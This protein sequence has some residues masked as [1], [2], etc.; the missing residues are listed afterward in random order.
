MESFATDGWIRRVHRLTPLTDQERSVKSR[1]RKEGISFKSQC[2][3]VASPLEKF[4]V[5]F[6][7]QIGEGCIVECTFCAKRRGKALSE[8]KHRCAW[9]DYRFRV[10]KSS[11]PG[12]SCI[13]LAEAPNEDQQRLLDAL[14]PI[15]SSADAVCTSQ[16]S[17][18]QKLIPQVMS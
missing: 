5:D 2:F 4:V 12:I 11:R 17:L 15:L 16:D 6:L 1:L 18:I 14:N 10:L 13:A 3:I 9:T 8:L 7:V